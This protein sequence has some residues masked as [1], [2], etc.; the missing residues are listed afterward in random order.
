MRSLDGSFGREAGFDLPAGS[1]VHRP[2][3]WQPS[4]KSESRQLADS[5]PGKS[6]EFSPL[7]HVHR[8]SRLT[9]SPRTSEASLASRRARSAVRSNLRNQLGEGGVGLVVV[10]L[11][12]AGRMVAAAAVGEHQF[13]DVGLAAAVKNGLAGGEDGVLLLEAPHLVDGD[14]ALG[15][16]GVNHEAVGGEDGFFVAQVEHNQIL[17]HR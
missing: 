2:Y 8:S 13:A 7:F 6:T 5:R 1:E 17:V 9:K 16:E 14:V 11:T 12:G 15:E 10:D 4:G 3:R